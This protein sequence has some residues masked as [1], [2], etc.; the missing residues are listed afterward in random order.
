M[1]FVSRGDLVWSDPELEL[2]PTLQGGR[3]KMNLR[4]GCIL[5]LLALGVAACGGGGGGDGGGGGGGGT[6]PEGMILNP[7][8]TVSYAQTTPA[9]YSF[10]TTG[11]HAY[12][13]KLVSTQGD[14]DLFVTSQPLS[15]SSL[16]LFGFSFSDGVDY[17]SFIV[18]SSMS[19][20][21]K[22]IQ[23]SEYI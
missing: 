14:A 22:H 8:G 15:E 1:F 16:D 21:Q 4:N 12:S 5:F 7:S 13:T 10:N 17:V 3:N 9:T 20:L 2:E 18:P 6:L 19:F 23:H 11:M